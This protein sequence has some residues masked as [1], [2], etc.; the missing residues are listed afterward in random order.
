MA[1]TQTP[2]AKSPHAVIAWIQRVV[3]WVMALKP[4]RVILDYN[5]HRGAVLAAGLSSQACFAVWAAVGVAFSEVGLVLA[6]NHALQDALYEQLAAAVPG[7]I[8][9]GE[10]GA[11][12]P[13]DLVNTTVLTW[14][15][16]FAL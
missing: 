8:D 4:V 16:A 7:L 14:A 3:A 13:S 12:D 6:G 11:I 15:G 9:T 5:E 2:D 1:E 10:G